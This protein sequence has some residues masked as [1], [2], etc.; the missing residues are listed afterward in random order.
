M[1][2]V[3]PNIPTIYTL[4]SL[5]QNYKSLVTSS[6]RLSTGLRIN[7]AADDAA[8]LQIAN[9]LETQ[10]NGMDVATR[11]ANDAISMVQVAEG[12]MGETTN[13]LNRIRDLSLQ[14]ANSSVSADDRKAMQYEVDQLLAQID[15]IANQTNYSGIQL[16]DGS[17]S[18]LSFQVGSNA[19]ETLPLSIGDMGIASLGQDTSYEAIIPA[20]VQVNADDRVTVVFNSHDPIVGNINV[21]IHD[22]APGNGKGQVITDEMI[23]SELNENDDLKRLGI[24][25]E[26]NQ[27]GNIQLSGDN[28]GKVHNS[29]FTSVGNGDCNRNPFR[30]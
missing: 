1:L 25:A 11:N 21:V 24:S 16:L 2:S 23:V 3:S 22:P 30:Y 12:A 14:S 10:I 13:I 17:A 4:N 20:G 19:G 6:R 18:N 27:S 28:L 5:N 29:Y 26:I 7:S 15:D 8:G 9:R